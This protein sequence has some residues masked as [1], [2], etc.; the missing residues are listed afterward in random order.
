[1]ETSL[2]LAFMYTIYITK[3]NQNKSP[4][5]T[6]GGSEVFMNNTPKG[7]LAESP[8][9]PTSFIEAPR[10]AKKLGI[11]FFWPWRLSNAPGFQVSCRISPGF[12]CTSDDVYCGLLREFR[13]G[14]GLRL[15]PP[16]KE[17]H[18]GDVG[19]CGQS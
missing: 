16:R 4:C 18:R 1:M 3:T 17:M 6:F 10:L 12:S 14:T 13:P 15:L 5:G 7:Q 8:V 11:K 19:Q 9:Q 2:T